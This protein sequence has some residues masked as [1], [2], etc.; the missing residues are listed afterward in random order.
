M[1]SYRVALAVQEIGYPSGMES[2]DVDGL[3]VSSVVI[4]LV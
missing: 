3:T 2:V 4:P 1:P